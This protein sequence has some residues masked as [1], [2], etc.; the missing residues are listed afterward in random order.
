M[1]EDGRSYLEN[2]RK[3]ALAF[4]RASSLVAM[5]DDTGLEVDALDGAPGLHSKRFAGRHYAAD[6][7]R[8]AFLLETLRDKP[9]PWRAR[10]HATIAIATPAGRVEFA[11]GYCEGEIVPGERGAGGFGYDAIFQVDALPKTMAE[12]SMEEKNQ[13]SHRARAVQAAKPLL[14]ELLDRSEGR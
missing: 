7:D 5:A 6:A 13:L 9:R 10:F 1:E 8:R 12:L 4:A 3:K 2:A 11:E 14:R